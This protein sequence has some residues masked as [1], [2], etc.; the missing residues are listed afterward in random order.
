MELNEHFS[1]YAPNYKFNPL[2]KSK[3]WDGKI[4]LFQLGQSRLYIGLFWDLFKFCHE[5]GYTIRFAKNKNGP[6]VRD[7][8]LANELDEKDAQI[9]DSIPFVYGEARDY[10]MKAILH[11]IENKRA[12]ILSPT[13]CL[14]GE[15]E[16]DCYIEDDETRKTFAE[17]YDLYHNKNKTIYFDTPNGKRKIIG[18][19]KKYGPGRTI[20]FNDGSIMKGANH[21]LMMSNGQFIPLFE[22]EEGDTVTGRDNKE[23]KTITSIKELKDDQYWYDFSVDDPSESYLLDGV[24]HHNSGKSAIIYYIALWYWM[25]HNKPICIVVPST[26]LCEQMKKDFINYSEGKI[27][28]DFIHLLYG[29]AE[30]NVEAPIYISTWQSLQN[31]NARS[32]YSQ[33]GMVITD[34]VHGTDGK[35]TASVQERFTDASFRFGFTGTLKDAKSSEIQLKGLFGPIYRT[36]KTT[37]LQQRKELADLSIQCIT[38]KYDEETRREHHIGKPNWQQEV[39]LIVSSDKRNQFIAKLALDQKNGNTLILF[40][41][42]KKHGKEIFG[43]LKDLNQD[44]DRKI[45]FVSGATDVDEREMVRELVEK[46]TNAIIVA[47]SGV[48]SQGINIVNLNNIIF[49]FSTKSHVRVIQSIGRAL[50]RSEEKQKAVIYDIIDN[51]SWKSKENFSLRHAHKRIEFYEDEGFKYRIIEVPFEP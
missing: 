11:G 21:H 38:L 41:L 44:K 33:F 42:V 12:V 37:E 13:G 46:E 7:S 19:Y 48:F 9:L 47:S 2:Y 27:D 8:V 43:I 50:R 4:R 51:I 28:D 24:I 14:D 16:I 1:F 10:Q 40:T 25:K 32:F 31:I 15:T 26:S 39:D 22:F 3:R 17:L 29:G 49:T 35:T 34:E 36:I 45:F 30:R 18:A 6:S 5:R 20:T 23:I